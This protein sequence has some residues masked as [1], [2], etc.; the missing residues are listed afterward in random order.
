MRIAFSTTVLL[1]NFFFLCRTMATD[2]P[3]AGLLAEPGDLDGSNVV[4]L[5]ARERAKYDAGHIPAARFVD[6]VAWAK[7]F[8]PTSSAADWANRIGALGISNDATV[9]VYDDNYTKDAARIWWLLR[10]WG[11]DNV[12]ILNGGWKAWLAAGR[13]A[14]KAEA[15]A[16]RA[17]F[18]PRV[19]EERLATKE[20]LLG[21]LKDGKFQIVDARSEAEHCG[22]DKLANRRAGAIPGAKQLEWIDLLDKRTQQFKPAA[23]LRQ[24]FQ[25]AGINL[26]Q[27]T[28]THC[29]SG[30]RSSVMA[31]GMELMGADQVSNYYAS[32]AEWGNADDTP[33]V[34]GKPKSP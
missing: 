23:E 32:W 30:G 13:D 18:T 12:R 3:N 31:F 29:Q 28:A 9:F 8:T 21:S 25:D 26:R 10:Y 14:S 4:I 7:A 24:L 22:L 16:V 20:Q 27:P 6:A 19:R 2:Y 33:V 17:A 1:V 11:V 34:P 5:D 15:V